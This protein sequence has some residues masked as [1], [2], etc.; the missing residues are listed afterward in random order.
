[1]SRFVC[2]Y[3]RLAMRHLPAPLHHNCGVPGNIHEAHVN[4]RPSRSSVSYD[5]TPPLNSGKIR[6]STVILCDGHGLVVGSLDPTELLQYAKYTCLV[7]VL[8]KQSCHASVR[9]MKMNDLQ[10]VLCKRFGQS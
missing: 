3:V 10:H 9:F 7:L 4:F 2:N 1:M 5:E 8:I 6:Y